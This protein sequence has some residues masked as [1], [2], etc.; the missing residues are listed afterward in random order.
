MKK[1]TACV[2]LKIVSLL[3]VLMLA[4]SMTPPPGRT[5]FY[6]RHAMVVSSSAIASEIGRD[7]MKQGGNAIDAAVATAFA[8]AVTWPSAGNIGGGGFIVYVDKNRQA[9]TFDFREKAPLTASENMFQ[10]S[11][12]RLVENFNHESLLS[13]GTPGTVAGLF[14]AHQRF[15]KLPWKK[16]VDPAVKL[17]AKGFVYTYALMDDA[18]DSKDTWSRIPSTARVIYKPG[19]TVYEPGE[20]WK[21][22]DLAATLKRIRDKGRDGF[23]KGETAKRLAAFMKA[24]GGLITEQDLA[25][26]EAVERKPVGGTYRGYTVYAMPPPSSGGVALIEMLNILELYDLKRLGY[27]SADY[28]HV[29]TETMKRAYAD[30][31]AHLGDPDFNPDLPAERLLSKEY[32]QRLRQTIRMDLASPSDSSRFGQIYDGGANTTHFSVMDAEGNAVSLT[33][34]LEY[35]YGSQIIADGLGFFLNNEMGDFN[36]VAGETKRNG[37]IGTPPNLI[38]PGKRMLSSMT[39]TILVKEGKPT[40]II[41]T[42]GGRTIINTVLQVILNVV[43]HDMNIAEAVE[44]PRIHHQWLPEKI[45]FEKNS[46]NNDTREALQRRGHTL[47]EYRWYQGSAM[48][49]FADRK[50]GFLMG[51]VDSRSPDGGAAGY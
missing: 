11:A 51:G 21:Q 34:T 47:Q 31:A 26:Y 2:S 1:I 8:M 16:L 27:R 42:P 5:P 12:G 38:R 32:A 10:D 41:G 45:Y 44:A 49:I 37:Q 25:Q 46:I 43:D 19:N 4:S 22:P 30:R 17:A 7:I 13:V 9:T 50:S 40:M 48:G 15:G 20:R 33:Y 14:L 6:A 36:P 3:V 24:N 35:S 29:L 18:E 23:Y 39:P 28:L